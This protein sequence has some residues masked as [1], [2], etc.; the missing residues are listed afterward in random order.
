MTI[1]TMNNQKKLK[2]FLISIIFITFGVVSAIFVG[3]RHVSD[4]EDNLVSIH[5]E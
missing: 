1:I 3:Y 5:S 4:K 2:F